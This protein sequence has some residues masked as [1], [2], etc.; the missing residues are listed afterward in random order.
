MTIVAMSN[1]WRAHQIEDFKRQFSAYG[2]SA[3]HLAYHAA[4]PVV[5]NSELLHLI[6]INF[7]LDPPESLPYD[8]EFDFLLSS[9][10][11]QIDEENFE[12]EP[13][14]RCYLLEKLFDK[15][16][17]KRISEI[18]SLLWEYVA[19]CSPWESRLTLKRA[20][21]ITALSILSPSKAIEWLNEAEKDR[22]VQ[23]G[24]D[25]SWYV[26]MRQ[27]LQ[28]SAKLV[29]KARS[30]SSPRH[31]S[32]NVRKDFF[33]SHTT[34]DGAWAEWIAWI[35]EAN[36]YTVHL[37]AWDFVPGKS[38][39][40]EMNQGVTECD[41]TIAI[42]SDNYLKAN[43]TQAEWAAAFRQ[44]PQSQVS[45]L[46]PIRVGECKPTGLLSQIIYIDI[47][48]R[49]EVEAER[50]ILEGIAA[51]LK[52]DGRPSKRPAFP[53]RDLA[54]VA[55]D[56][57]TSKKRF[58]GRV[59]TQNP[60]LP[61]TG[62]VDEAEQFFNGDRTLDRI[63][64]VL[65]SDSNV[66]LIGDRSLGKSSLL[67]EVARQAQGRLTPPREPIFINLV[68]LFSEDE[69]YEELC[70]KVGIAEDTRG[71][72]LNRALRNKHLLLILDEVE[73]MVQDGFS[74]RVRDQLRGLSEGK[75][76]P[77]RLVLAARRPLDQ[78]FPDG[79]DDGMVSPL[80][81]ICVEETIQPWSAESVRQF[82]T[83]RLSTTAVRFSEN[84]IADLI[85]TSGGSPKVLMQLC[86]QLFRSKAF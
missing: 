1:E 14:A 67:R 79:Y 85:A 19:Y 77:L 24:V 42:L 31:Q 44:D 34:P 26:V 74:R 75:D 47:V 23:H 76:A 49:T 30:K 51:A 64:K 45:R 9:I 60:F 2:D 33:I 53:N 15:Y 6:R 71:N 38:F 66:A 50:V 25:R 59:Q 12:I 32:S 72:K 61:L 63:F 5:L 84:E 39:V 58:P 62:A 69:F 8:I 20:Q 86:N 40:R 57:P 54:Q 55:D 4:V 43:F 82:I 13:K 56:V 22:S 18:A 68:M 16:G 83:T 48:G 41:H 52:Q 65:N 36:G 17:S 70:A 35:L 80:H 27:G 28:E 10:C 81:G 11:Y 46:I 21:Q 29:A 7:F 78:L 73:R 37:Q 3:L